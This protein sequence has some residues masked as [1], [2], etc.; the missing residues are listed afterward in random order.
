MYIYISNLLVFLERQAH[1]F[2]RAHHVK[3]V[4]A[5]LRLFLLQTLGQL[6]VF[7]RRL[8]LLW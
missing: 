8:I 7:A 3:L 6:V 4:Y 1:D 2:L 5:P